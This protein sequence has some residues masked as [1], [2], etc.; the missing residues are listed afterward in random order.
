MQYRYKT[1]K[2]MLT[3]STEGMSLE[4]VISRKNEM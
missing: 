3:F 1:A 4:K 2:P